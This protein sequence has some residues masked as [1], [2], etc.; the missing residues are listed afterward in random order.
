MRQTSFALLFLMPRI[1]K[2]DKQTVYFMGAEPQVQFRRV[3]ARKTDVRY[4]TRPLGGD[5]YCFGHTLECRIEYFGIVLSRL[6][7]ELTHAAPQLDPKLSLPE[8]PAQFLR[9]I[10]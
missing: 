2:L 3:M 7:G 1:T 6:G 8:K 10:G 4:P 9:R 5:N